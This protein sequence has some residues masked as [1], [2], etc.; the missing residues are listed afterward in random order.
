MKLIA[1][2]LKCRHLYRSPVSLHPSFATYNLPFRSYD[3][4][5][6]DMKYRTNN[7]FLVTYMKSLSEEQFVSHAYF[8][9]YLYE[10]NNLDQ[11]KRNSQSISE[12]ARKLLA[13]IRPTKKSH[14]DIFDI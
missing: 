6:V 2:I 12:F 14:Y 7:S 10:W 1:L 8:Q 9:N 13:I 4:I 11:N 5:R 3:D